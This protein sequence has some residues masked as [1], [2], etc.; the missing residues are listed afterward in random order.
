MLLQTLSVIPGFSEALEECIRWESGIKIEM[1]ITFMMLRMLW[2]LWMLA[3][4]I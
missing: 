3:I 1:V 4:L 2:L